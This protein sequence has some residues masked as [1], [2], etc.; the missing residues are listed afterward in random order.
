MFDSFFNV[1]WEFDSSSNSK[2]QIKPVFFFGQEIQPLELTT[3]SF[4]PLLKGS[5][6]FAK[7]SET[8]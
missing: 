6:F 3:H 5:I 7:I 4:T 1:V 2:I 8:T